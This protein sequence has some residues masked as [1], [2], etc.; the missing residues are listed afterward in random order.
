MSTDA[1]V[2]LDNVLPSSSFRVG[3]F[4]SSGFDLWKKGFW[5]FFG[6]GLLYMLIAG[7]V[8]QIPYLGQVITQLFLAPVLMGGAYMYCHHLR[9]DG[10]AEFET[11]FSQFKAGGNLL[12]A[13]LVY[14]LITL[15]LAV[16]FI[17][18]LGLEVF[19]VWGK[20]E[21]F[22]YFVGFDSSK[23]LLLLIPFLGSILFAYVVHFVIFYKLSAIDA[24]TYSAKFCLKHYILMVLFFIIV[25]VLVMLGVLG[26]VIGIFF[27]FPLVFP[28]SYE[29]FRLLTKLHHYEKRDEQ[30][31]V[32]DQL[33][34]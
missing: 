24:I 2:H 8:G 22:D 4:L 7:L 31:D 14:T 9:R 21:M 10:N 28:M 15:L 30:Q 19:E 1:K 3:E 13:Y 12:L 29:S 34:V 26:I 33:I 5:A 23:F 17:L 32:I 18:S 11:F 27:T 25:M 6:F 20:P 16:P